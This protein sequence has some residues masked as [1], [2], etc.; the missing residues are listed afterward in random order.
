[1]PNLKLIISNNKKKILSVFTFKII[2]L[3]LASY[4]IIDLNNQI[5]ELLEN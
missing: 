5:K 1:M 3:N 2:Y 4:E